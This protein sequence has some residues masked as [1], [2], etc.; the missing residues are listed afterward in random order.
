[1]AQTKKRWK[2]SRRDHAQNQHPVP[3]TERRIQDYLDT[4]YGRVGTQITQ[5][6]EVFTQRIGSIDIPVVADFVNGQMVAGSMRYR[7]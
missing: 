7:T 2:R 5:A 3:A 1:M 6:F 4:A